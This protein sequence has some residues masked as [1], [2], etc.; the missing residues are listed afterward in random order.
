VQP[1]EVVRADRDVLQAEPGEVGQFVG[2]A[3]SSVHD[4]LQSRVPTIRSVGNPRIG[5]RGSP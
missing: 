3:R 4:P 1:L 5:T 2:A